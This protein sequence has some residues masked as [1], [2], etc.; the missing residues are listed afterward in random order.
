MHPANYFPSPDIT[1][2]ERFSKMQDTQAA[3]VNEIKLN[4]D[5][6]IHRRIDMS[7]AELQSKQTMVYESGQTLVKIIDPNDLRHDIERRRKERLQNED[8]H[9]FHIASA[10]ERNDQQS[11]FSRLENTQVD[12]FQ[13]PTCFIESNFR[14]FIQKPYMNY[15]TMQ[16][17]D[18]THKPFGVEGNHENTRGFRRPFKTNFRGGRFQPHYKSGLV[19]KSLCIQAKYQHLRF[20]GPRGFITNKF[21]EKLLRKK[22]E[23]ANIATAV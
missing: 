16:R 23:Y 11:S 17:K 2:H 1:L 4:S 7:L 15:Q 5:P 13:K 14:K 8:E 9:I 20:A 22:K 19:Q 18:I 6:E 10:A 3:D 12:G 21:R